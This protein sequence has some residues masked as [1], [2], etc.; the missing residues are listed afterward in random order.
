[1][2]DVVPVASVDAEPYDRTDLRVQQGDENREFCLGVAGARPPA[3]VDDP[4]A[5]E[6]RIQAEPRRRRK[7]RGLNVYL[8]GDF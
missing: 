2:G 6:C 7:S 4:P 1:V 5:L 3:A 8:S